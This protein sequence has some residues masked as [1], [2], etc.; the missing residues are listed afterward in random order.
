MSGW[1]AVCM[2]SRRVHLIPRAITTIQ[3]ADELIV[4]CGF[5]V[6]ASFLA[7]A[8]GQRK[9]DQRLPRTTVLMAVRGDVCSD[10]FAADA[11]FPSKRADLVAVRCDVS[12]ASGQLPRAVSTDWGGPLVRNL[13]GGGS[14][15]VQIDLRARSC[16]G[17]IH[18]CAM[19]QPAVLV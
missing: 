18:A 10:H 12:R 2:R 15:P 19:I 9:A 11:P 14:V 13:Q 6:L 4:K 3:Q 5:A 1:L 8:Q 7:C 17:G 16:G